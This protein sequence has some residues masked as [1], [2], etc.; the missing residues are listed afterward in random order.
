MTATKSQINRWNQQFAD[1]TA[2]QRVELMAN[3]VTGQMAMTSSFGIH[4]AVTLHLI[5]QVIPGIPVIMVDTGYL[6]AETYQFAEQL[7]Q[8]LRLNLQVVQSPHSAARFEAIHGQLWTQGLTGI[9]QYNQLRK[10]QPLKQAL[11]QSEVDVWFS[12]VRR[13]QS[14]HRQSLPWVQL[15]NQRLKVHPLLDWSERDMYLYLQRHQLPQHPLWDQGYLTVGDTHTTRSIHE[16]DSE[17]QLRFMGLK[18][19]CGIHE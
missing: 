13:D 8:Q 14:E 7:Q 18:R 16:V 4:A 9:E 5:N 2:Q 17:D 15:K 19:E 6:F 12:G 11:Q 1:L 10:V 3:E